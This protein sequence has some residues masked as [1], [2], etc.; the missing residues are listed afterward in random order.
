MEKQLTLSAK[1]RFDAK[2]PKVQKELFEYAASLG[3]FR[4]LTDF[5]INAVQEKASAIIQEHNTIIA[6]EKDR[7][8]FFN[9]LM[10]PSG[11]NQKLK[12]AAEKYKLFIRENK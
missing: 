6:S 8:I 3:G 12:D 7:E 9:A 1:A 11:P 2:I 10:N 4:T 5:I